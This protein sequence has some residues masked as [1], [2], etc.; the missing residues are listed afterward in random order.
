M[1]LFRRVARSAAQGDSATSTALDARPFLTVLNHFDEP[2]SL[3]LEPWG[4]EYVVNKGEFIRVHSSDV[5][6][7]H[8][9]TW[10]VK[11]GV[12][13]WLNRDNQVR[14]FSNDALELSL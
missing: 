4:T 13:V 11:E 14:L 1:R 6:T 9:E 3:F 2:F 7:E 5:G 10:P 8:L 12:V